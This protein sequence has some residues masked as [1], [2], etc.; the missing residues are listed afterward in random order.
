MRR[1]TCRSDSAIMSNVFATSRS[2]TVLSTRI[3]TFP[4]SSPSPSPAKVTLAD[5]A[6]Q[7]SSAIY[8]F[9]CNRS[10]NDKLELPRSSRTSNISGSLTPAAISLGIQRDT[11]RTGML[12]GT[13][14]ISERSAPTLINGAMIATLRVAFSNSA[15]TRCPSVSRSF[16]RTSYGTL[17]YGIESS[18]SSKNSSAYL[19]HSKRASLT[20]RRGL[21]G[22]SSSYRPAQRQSR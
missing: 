20:C 9:A 6:R 14:R 10:T 12:S 17:V 16:T 13:P 18:S 2:S 22:C 4:P 5:P 15:R 8:S 7:R 21:F 11:Q 1:V 3:S 19:P